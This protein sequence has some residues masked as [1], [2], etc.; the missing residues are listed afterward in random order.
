MSTEYPL[1]ELASLPSFYHPAASPDGDAIAV[2]YDG[3]GR[4]ELYIVDPETGE[5]TQVSDGN[6]PR[7]ARYPFRWAPS[8]EQFYL[9][10][11]RATPLPQEATQAEGRVAQ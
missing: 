9:K 11:R 7:D 3:T 1:E 10:C 4:N 6:I 8:R 2:Y 5:K